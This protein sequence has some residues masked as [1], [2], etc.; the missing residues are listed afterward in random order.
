M[1][2]SR[3]GRRWTAT[4]LRVVV[5]SVLAREATSFG[6]VVG[7]E[8]GGN[9]T[10]VWDQER[11]QLLPRPRLEC[12][13]GWGQY[14]DDNIRLHIKKEW[15]RVCYYC[16]HMSTTSS[17]DMEKLVA[18]S[19]WDEQQFY[20]EFYVLG[21]GGMF[22]TPKFMEGNN[23]CNKGSIDLTADNEGNEISAVEMGLVC[24][25]KQGGCSAAAR[26]FDR[27]LAMAGAALG[28][29]VSLHVML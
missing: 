25:N 2:R 20:R 10:H 1:F 24:C 7:E 15:T 4:G 9:E 16:M 26:V 21:C 19:T 18:G 13:V 14:N 8:R 29:A 6:A 17:A 5:L 11:R 22:G 28:V 12:S 23:G 27:A 3:G